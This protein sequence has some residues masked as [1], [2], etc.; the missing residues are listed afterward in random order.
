MSNELLKSSHLITFLK[1]KKLT[2]QISTYVTKKA[3]I[4]RIPLP[5]LSFIDEVLADITGFLLTERILIEYFVNNNI[6]ISIGLDVFY[7]QYAWL[8]NTNLQHLVR[9]E[10]INDTHIPNNY[11][12]TCILISSE[13]FRKKYNLKQSYHTVFI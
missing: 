7:K 10:N 4:E 1:D 8:W 13:H 6:N 12:V 2:N 9:P 11:R 3:K 5:T